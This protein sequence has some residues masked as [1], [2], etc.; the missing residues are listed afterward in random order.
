MKICALLVPSEMKVEHAGGV[1]AM[2]DD[3]IVAAIAAIEEMLAQPECQGDRGGGRSRPELASAVYAHHGI[4]NWLS[5]FLRRGWS[6]F[7][8]GSTGPFFGRVHSEH[9]D[10]LPVGAGGQLFSLSAPGVSFWMQNVD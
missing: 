1:K 10:D 5:T 3:A 9:Q 7:R 4:V 2:T 8:R 6:T